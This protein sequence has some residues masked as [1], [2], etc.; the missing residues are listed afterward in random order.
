MI[1]ID[2]SGR[3][4][5]TLSDVLRALEARDSDPRL[6]LDLSDST[7]VQSAAGRGR[8]RDMAAWAKDDLSA[9]GDAVIDKRGYVFMPQFAGNN[10]Q[11]YRKDN[12]LDTVIVCPEFMRREYGERACFNKCT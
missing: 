1:Q 11:L 12:I 9:W 2:V 4:P 6:V 8:P 5:Q 10:F 3:G 7:D